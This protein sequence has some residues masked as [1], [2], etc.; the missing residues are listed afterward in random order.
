[1]AA[2]DH[3]RLRTARAG[4]RAKSTDKSRDTAGTK[5]GTNGAP[6]TK[7][8]RRSSSRGTP[9]EAPSL[10]TAPAHTL[11]QSVAETGAQDQQRQA[12]APPA[13]A[14]PCAYGPDDHGDCA[15]EPPIDVDPCEATAI[16]DA[17]GLR[18]VYRE[19]S[20]I[21]AQL[22]LAYALGQTFQRAVRDFIP[23]DDVDILPC[24]SIGVLDI[25]DTQLP[26]LDALL[27]VLTGAAHGIYRGRAVV[28]AKPAGGRPLRAAHSSPGL[29]DS[30]DEGSLRRAVTPA[31]DPPV[32]SHGFPTNMRRRSL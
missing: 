14:E 29:S 32:A 2:T 28:P 9:P 7:T 21:H 18:A 19:V 27:D 15:S 17:D 23:I 20:D 22:A 25:I 31:A 11:Y 1:M 6:A 8:R 30:S 5:S 16:M 4:A 13:P 26:R 24:L 3:T 12:T 10:G